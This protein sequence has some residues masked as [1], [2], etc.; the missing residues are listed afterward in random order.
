MKDEQRERKKQEGDHVVY[1]QMSRSSSMSSSDVEDLDRL[2]GGDSLPASHFR[3]QVQR[4][5]NH[6]I[7]AAKIHMKDYRPS[8]NHEGWRGDQHP[9]RADDEEVAKKRAQTGQSGATAS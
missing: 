9:P 3:H 7:D 4:E 8:K 5:A 1:T 6:K 2:E